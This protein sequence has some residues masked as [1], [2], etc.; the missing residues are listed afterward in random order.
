MGLSEK[1]KKY[2][3]LGI[4]DKEIMK[5]VLENMK[6]Q[7]IAEVTQIK[8]VYVVVSRK[9]VNISQK[10]SLYSAVSKFSDRLVQRVTV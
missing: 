4:L 5:D 10:Q 1:N 9:K 8:Q 3:T 6:Y 2:I 7:G